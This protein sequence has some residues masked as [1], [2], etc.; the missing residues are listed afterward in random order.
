VLALTAGR[1]AEADALVQKA[2]ALGGRS[3]PEMAMPIYQ[4]QRYALCEFRGGVDEVEDAI[5]EL[6]AEYP[7]RPVIRCAL[8]HL[9]TRL[10]RLPEAKRAL[11]HLARGEFSALPFDPEWL[12]G[13]SFLAETSA[14]LDEVDTAAVLY[15]LLLPWAAFNAADAYEGIRGSV[16]RYLGLLAVTL[17]RWDDAAHHFEDALEMNERM[18][19]RPWLAR[20]QDD[21]AHLLFRRG[22]AGDAA[23]ARSLLDSAQI[24]YRELGMSPSPSSVAGTLDPVKPSS[25]GG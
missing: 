20:T 1:F 18:G 2:L 14:L 16:S 23:E 21:Y 11:K 10:G 12:Y 9:E 24:T 17:C 5:R 3:Q 25:I 8:A 4:L 7:A 6:A 13:L 19:A 15:D 22:A